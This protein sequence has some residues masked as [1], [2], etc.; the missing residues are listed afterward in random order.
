MG[1]LFLFCMMATPGGYK[2]TDAA[3]TEERL[4][5]K[6]AITFGVDL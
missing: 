5:W 6:P 4:G 2:A 1:R 3:R